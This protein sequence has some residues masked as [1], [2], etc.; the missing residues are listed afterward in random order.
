MKKV[1]KFAQ[2]G[3]FDADTYERAQAFLALKDMPEFQQKYQENVHAAKPIKRSA[4]KPQPVPISKQRA[5]AYS[6]PKDKGEPA[7]DLGIRQE[8]VS[9]DQD[10]FNPRFGSDVYARARTMLKEKKQANYDQTP[11]LSEA[12]FEAVDREIKAFNKKKSGGMVSSAS[13]RA[14]GIASKG[15]TRGRIY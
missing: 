7:K 6:R 13:K 9:S 15:K 4:P 12:N 8:A 3:K 5:P 14:D 2:G 11:A 10:Q 1:R